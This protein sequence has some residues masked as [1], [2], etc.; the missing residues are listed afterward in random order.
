MATLN[1]TN[2]L[3]M[4]CILVH[5]HPMLCARH[6]SHKSHLSSAGSKQIVPTSGLQWPFRSSTVNLFKE[7]EGRSLQPRLCHQQ[8]S[9]HLLCLGSSVSFT[10]CL[11]PLF[12][13]PHGNPQPLQTAEE[14][15]RFSYILLSALHSTPTPVVMWHAAC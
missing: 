14:V 11:L 2:H 5:G 3:E 9:V 15:S 12:P 13:A 4:W 1:T 10:G 6:G 7:H 8:P